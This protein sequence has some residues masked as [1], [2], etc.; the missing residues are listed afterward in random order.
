MYIQRHYE[1][2]ANFLEPNITVILL[3]PRQVGKTTLIKN[4]L[5]KTKLKYKF[6]TGD[7]IHTQ[8][9]LG[10]QDL[11]RLKD[12]CFGQELIVIDEAHK[13][14]NVGMGFKMI[15][16]H[17]PNIKII[18][19]G[20]SSFELAGQV[21][22]PLVGRK[23]TL[24]LYPIS[25]LELINH[26]SRFDL[27]ERLGERLIYGSYP[28]TFSLANKTQKR[29]YLEDVLNSLL[30]KDILDL[31][32]VKGSKQLL[33][34][35]RLVAFQVGNEVSCAELGRGLELN[36]KTVAR[37][38][39]LLEKSFILYNLRGFSRNLRKEITK[40]SKYYFYDNGI[41][42][43]VISNFN[44]LPLRDDVGRL[45][46]NYL[47]IERLKSCSY[48]SIYSNKYFWRTHDQQEI[49][50]I[51]ERDGRLFGFEFKWGAHKYR[52]PKEF[53]KTYPEGE[54]TVIN[55]ENYLPFLGC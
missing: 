27:Q 17:V 44:D 26:W 1:D 33:D 37:Y 11:N 32:T 13:I 38:L 10:S 54:V 24:T 3:G 23:K 36:S 48:R 4:F 51:E 16:D 20:S 52:P 53:L 46:E 45:W 40:K 9:V 25:E 7:D 50:L 22:E 31:E 55:K 18:A 49:D 39:D 42:N 35:L 15:V 19:T 34:L 5:E 41:R 30:L 29:E 47:F 43:A 12:Y 28:H 21:G 8:D 14:R 6:E 2:L